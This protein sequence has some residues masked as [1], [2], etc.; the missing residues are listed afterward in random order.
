[1]SHTVCCNQEPERIMVRQSVG[2][3]VEKWP[4]LAIKCR[5]CGRKIEQYYSDLVA[6]WNNI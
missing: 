1:M 3:Q 2:G 5:V 4:R 6:K